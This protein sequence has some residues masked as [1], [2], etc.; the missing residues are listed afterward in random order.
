M[1]AQYDGSSK[2]KARARRQAAFTY[3]SRRA[4]LTR[5]GAML[6]DDI[7]DGISICAYSREA[8]ITAHFKA[9]DGP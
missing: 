1:S 4:A 5:S 6:D 2:Q 3:E 9:Y 8:V 7:I